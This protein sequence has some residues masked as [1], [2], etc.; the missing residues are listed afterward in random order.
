MVATLAHPAGPLQVVAACLEYEPAYNDDRIAQ[1]QAL[2]DLATDPAL[3]GPLPV[4]VAG[5]LNAAPDSPVC[6]H[7]RTS[8]S[9]HGPP[10][11]ATRR[12]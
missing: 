10:A 2:V 4:I 5:D 6:A 11:A 9:T 7:C 1:A 8:S 12:R 3:D